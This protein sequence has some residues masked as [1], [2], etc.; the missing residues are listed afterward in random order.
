L[1]WAALPPA[2]DAHAALLRQRLK[3][4][5]GHAMLLRGTDQVRAAIDVFHPQ[6]A[7]V[8]ALGQRVKASFDPKQ[9]LNRGRMVRI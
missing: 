6:E 1:I 3:P 7:G 5:G 8:A 4:I 9:I 2:P